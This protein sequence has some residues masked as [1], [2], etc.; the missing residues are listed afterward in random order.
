MA[1]AR[2]SCTKLR[3]ATARQGA[4]WRR[5]LRSAGANGRPKFA[6][7]EADGEVIAEGDLGGVADDAAPS[8]IA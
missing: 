5:P 1:T 4:G 7:P 3:V 8:L 2:R 6:A